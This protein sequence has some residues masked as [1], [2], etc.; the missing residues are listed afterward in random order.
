MA[1]R[2]LAL[3]LLSSIG[4]NGTGLCKKTCAFEP[5]AWH[6]DHFGTNCM[7]I[8]FPADVPKFMLN[9]SATPYELG[10]SEYEKIYQPYETLPDEYYSDPYYRYA[11][12]CKQVPTSKCQK[13]AKAYVCYKTKNRPGNSSIAELCR[14]H[15]GGNSNSNVAGFSV[16]I[17]V[18]RDAKE[19]MVVVESFFNLSF[20]DETKWNNENVG[21]GSVLNDIEQEKINGTWAKKLHFV[22]PSTMYKFVPIVMPKKICKWN[23]ENV[24]IGSV[25]NDIEQEKINGTW[26]KKLHFVSPSTSQMRVFFQIP[27][28]EFSRLI[29]QDERLKSSKNNPNTRNTYSPCDVYGDDCDEIRE[30]LKAIEDLES[31]PF[32]KRSENLICNFDA[33]CNKTEL[34]EE[35]I[36]A[37]KRCG[38]APEEG[39]R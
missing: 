14:K 18:H 7:E 33:P 29:T 8:V 34:H 31:L 22:S 36:E 5:T 28:P 24:G 20:S 30:L 13:Q 6:K 12:A 15:L 11:D 39:N 32:E 3:D 2:I 23:N 26:A 1:F 35:Y 21:I 37:Q 38:L 17:C 25:L 16:Q 9:I 27:N 19:N 4:Q 10:C